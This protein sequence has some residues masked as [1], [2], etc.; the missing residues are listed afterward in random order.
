MFARPFLD[1]SKYFTPDELDFYMDA[2]KNLQLGFGGYCQKSWMICK[3][4]H[5]FIEQYNPSIQFLEL[6][7]MTAGILAWIHRFKNH[8]IIVHCDNDSVVKMLWNSSTKSKQCM[9]LIRLVVLHCMVHNV[10]LH[11][12][13]VKT[14]DNEIANSLSRF[15]MQRFRR[16]TKN[17]KMES[18]PT[19]VPADL[20]PP[21]KL[22][23]N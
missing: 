2:S 14:Q 21:E 5:N 13:H 22:I 3:W 16:L 6:Y 10:K 1:F 18:A 12:V 20:W 23:L 11:L 19:Q 15:Q 7:A 4:S 17:H 8:Q 9:V